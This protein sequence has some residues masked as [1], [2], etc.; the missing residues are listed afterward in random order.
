MLNTSIQGIYFNPQ[1]R[2]IMAVGAGSSAPGAA[3][4]RFTEDNRLGL[5]ASRR[6]LERLGLT[7]DARGVEWYGISASDPEQRRRVSGLV[8]A[9]RN[10]SERLRHEAE[11]KREFWRRLISFFRSPLPSRGEG[12]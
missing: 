3:W 6:E 5:L 9:F 11:S 10:D 1:R 12:A 2:E 7:D 8:G 4:T